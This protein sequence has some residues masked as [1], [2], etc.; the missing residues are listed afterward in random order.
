MQ[1]LRGGREGHAHRVFP[2]I[3]YGRRKA[4]NFVV[5]Q[6]MHVAALV[7]THLDDARARRVQRQM[8][9]CGYKTWFSQAA[10]PTAA[11]APPRGG[12]MIVARAYLD[13]RVSK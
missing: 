10:K 5:E 11:G 12:T 13:V 6:K 8:L 1:R 9:S 2:N 4:F 3:T 7:E